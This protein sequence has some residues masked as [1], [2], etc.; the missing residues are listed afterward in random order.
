MPRLDVNDTELYYEDTGPGRSGETVLMS[1]GLLWSA[2]MFAPQALALSDEYRIVSYDHRGQGRSAESE[3]RSIDMGT[4]TADA[5]LLIEKLELAPMHFV[6][7]SMGGFVGL[8]VAARRPE[9]LC[10]LTLLETS[11]DPEPDE[12][13]ASY[14]AMSFV[15]RRFGNR[16]LANRVM[17]IMFG[18]TFM[19]DPAR[20]EERAAWRQ[21]LIDNRRSMWRALNGVLERETVYPEL[22]RI[23]APT[24]IAVG[25][26]DVATPRPNSERLHAAI[27]GSRLCVIPG[28]GHTS[29]IEQP[30]AVTALLREHFSRARAG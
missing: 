5:I 28:A 12:N 9:L 10:S 6:G 29:S 2:E 15:V 19:T 7:L 27:A 14:R 22:G 20:S 1:H 13:I 16:L 17:R 23:R 11:G 21:R 30:E 24:L 3:M 8:R 25:A 4:V 26:E 18:K